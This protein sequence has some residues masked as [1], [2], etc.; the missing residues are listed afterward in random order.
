MTIRNLELTLGPKSVA[1]I[2]ASPRPGSVGRVVLENILKGGFKGAVY[3]VNLKHDEVSGLKCY[4]R[5]ADLPEAPDLAVLVTPPDTIPGLIGELGVRGTKVAVV[6]TAGIHG[7]LRQQMLDAAKPHLLRIIGPNTIGLVAPP[8]ALNAS[9]VH[10]AAANGRLGLISQ[11]GA[12]VSSVIDWAAAEGIGFSQVYS[13]GDMAD[14]DVGDCLNVLAADANTSAILI[15]L[16]SIPAARKF[17]SAARA[18]SRVKPV[19]AVK[20]GR[21]SEAAKA[22]AT[23]TGAL[24]GADRVVDAALRRAG[25]IR[26]DDL[27]DLFNA[28]EIT[29]RFAPLRQ[30]R[31]AIV[32]N[33]GGAGVLAVDQLLDQGCALAALSEATLAALDAALPVTWSHANPVDIIGDAPP[34]RYAA[35]LSAVGADPGVDAILV[36]NCPTALADP[37][38]AAGSVVT[39]ASSGMIGGKPVLAC[40][41]GKQAAEPARALLQSAGIASF[42]TPAQAAE[43]VA[44][45]TRWSELRA[46]LE[47]V[48]PSS[49]E[50]TVDRAAATQ[51]LA[52]V[53]A[54]GRTILT[55]FEAKSLLRAYG[56]PVLETLLVRDEAQV[57]AA[58]TKLLAT[59][60]SLVVKMLSKTIT[61]KSDIGGVVLNLTSA[62]DIG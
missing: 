24:A 19:I 39:L 61:H 16:E 57:E 28:A 47:R 37:V 18:A 6:I 29:A 31:V 2:G 25:I 44:L 45:L 12:I 1:V 38:A 58:A 26:V 5:V 17:M 35:A 20:P 9:F 62:A 23:H 43:A 50:F 54:E 51:I 33:G 7:D 41:L 55:E 15:Y 22:A 52:V 27:D 13:L 46:R 48:P 59:A 11:S 8:A 40:W 49:A 14:V 32:T 4:R 60:P 36:M 42:D 3:P 34:E 10:V 21:H 56:V 53:A 30:G